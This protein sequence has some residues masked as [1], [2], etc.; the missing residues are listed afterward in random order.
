MN[1]MIRTENHGTVSRGGVEGNILTATNQINRTQAEL[2]GFNSELPDLDTALGLATADL[3]DPTGA[4]NEA[5]TGLDN[6]I[7]ALSTAEENMIEPR[8]A[9]SIAELAL[10]GDVEQTQ[11]D[12]DNANNIL[13]E[14]QLSLDVCNNAKDSAQTAL[15]EANAIFEPFQTAYDEANQNYTSKQGEI[16]GSE[17]RL[18]GY[19]ESKTLWES[20]L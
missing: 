2:D 5:Q 7:E 13:A 16:T 18:V 6:C 4:V 3:I 11:T 9:V 14:F 1:G 15:D 10:D 17:S 12:L 8:E 20:Y 19:N